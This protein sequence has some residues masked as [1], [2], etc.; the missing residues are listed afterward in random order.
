MMVIDLCQE[1]SDTETRSRSPTPDRS[2]LLN[3]FLRPSSSS[4]S[5]VKR[6]GVLNGD[7]KPSRP[8]SKG[9]NSNVSVVIPYRADLNH[10]A[11]NDKAERK[12]TFPTHHGMSDFY[13]LDTSVEPYKKR[14]FSIRAQIDIR[15]AKKP[16]V[17]RKPTSQSTITDTLKK[18][19]DLKLQTIKGPQI[20]F[21]AG[22]Q[23]KSVNFN[24]E[25]LNVYKLQAGVEAVDPAFLTG[26]NCPEG[27]CTNTCVCLALEEDSDQ[28]IIPYEK[29][30]QGI[31]VLRPEFIK[32]NS[33][34]CEC[35][36]LCSCKTKCWNQVVARRRTVRL[37]IFSTRHRG[38]GLRSPDPIQRGQFIDTYIGEVVTRAMADDRESSIMTE[39]RAS[40]F[41][42]LDFFDRENFLY[43]I[44]GQKYGS[45]TRFMNH[46]CNPNCKL[47]SVSYHADTQIFELAFFAI[48]DIPANTELTFDYQPTRGQVKRPNR[49]DPDALRCLCGERNCRGQLWV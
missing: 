10:I 6:F 16:F 2:V 41:F 43:V 36:S 46:S 5:S 26:C 25:F 38:F 15:R 28:M 7:L 42:S 48:M 18:L 13:T 47:F 9:S 49:I 22:D 21:N 12:P 1:D 35:S 8:V 19:Y 44:D 23:I 20:I 24:F 3:A 27:K 37:E 45:I 11:S 33:M 17:P 31:T 39:N 30:S 32:R 40:Y 4:G 29:G 34:I 14:H